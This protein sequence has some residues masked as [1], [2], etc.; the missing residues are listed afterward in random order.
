MLHL[1]LVVVAVD[2]EALA[3]NPGVA[4]LERVIQGEPAIVHLRD[5]HIVPKAD[6]GKSEGIKCEAL[7]SA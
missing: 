7:K 3:W 2:I 4:K 1:L 6:Y 5:W